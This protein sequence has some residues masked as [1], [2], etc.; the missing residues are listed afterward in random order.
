MIKENKASKYLLYAIG[1]V[2]LVVIGILLALQFNAWNTNSK[3]LEKEE[4]YLNNILDDIHYQTQT[5]EIIVEEY[6]GTITA[7]KSIL[8][9]YYSQKSF[10]GIDSLNSKLNLL[11]YAQFFPNT[12][13]SY[14]ELV[15]SGQLSLI[16]NKNISLEVIDFYLYSADN[17]EVFKN[18]I[19]NIFYPQI[20]PVISDLVQVDIADFL[21][22]DADNYLLEKLPPISSLI[23]EKLQKFSTRL[24][25][26][27]AIKLKILILSDQLEVIQETQKGAKELSILI[28]KELEEHNHD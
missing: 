24:A 2:L 26:E 11:M 25:L 3:E 16:K 10:I 5:L 8:K 15:S 20:Y 18:D 9:D 21:K 6:G 4:W 1:E 12:N 19:D 14:Q 23:E 22:D 13:N 27:N 28:E 7:A 17:E